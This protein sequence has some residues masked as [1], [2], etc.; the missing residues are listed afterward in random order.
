MTQ[1]T[2][3]LPE[4]PPPPPAPY[5]VRIDIDDDG[6]ADIDSTRPREYVVAALRKVADHL[7]AG[8]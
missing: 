1:H 7:E 6:H 2:D 4:L 5:V 8:T 3:E